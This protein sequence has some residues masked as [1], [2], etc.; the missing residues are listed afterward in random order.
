LIN[1]KL[2]VFRVSS[3]AAERMHTC[4]NDKLL[5]TPS[6]LLFSSFLCFIYLLEIKKNV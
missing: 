3:G 2:V 4:G 1:E 6:F 5:E